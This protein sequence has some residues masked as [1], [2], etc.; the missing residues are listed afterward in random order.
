MS[1]ALE[2]VEQRN[3]ERHEARALARKA[4]IDAHYRRSE[5]RLLLIFGV[6]MALSALF[7]WVVAQLPD[8]SSEALEVVCRALYS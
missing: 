4:E 1:D 7:Q 3:E 5:N 8:L 6:L 2:R